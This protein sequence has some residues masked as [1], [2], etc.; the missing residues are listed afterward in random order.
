MTNT[1]TTPTPAKT[2]MTYFKDPRTRILLGDNLY[3]GRI[4]AKTITVPVNKEN[5]KKYGIVSPKDYDKILDTVTLQIASSAQSMSKTDLILLNII[6]NYDWDRPIYFLQRGG[7][8]NIGIKEYLQYE[9]F[10]YKLVPIKSSTAISTNENIENWQLDADKTYDFLMNESRLSSLAADYNVDY[11]NLLTFTSLVPI[12]EIMVN[13]SKALILQGDTTK[14]IN[15]LD[16]MQEV[17]PTNNYPLNVSYISSTN[18]LAVIEAI[19]T[20]LQCGQKE[21]AF[22]IANEFVDETLKHLELQSNK[23]ARIDVL[24]SNLL[25]L[26]YL[27]ENY[28]DLGYVAEAAEIKEIFDSY[29][30]AYNNQ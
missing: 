1:F 4:L 11:Q 14:A 15:L 2:I 25:Y 24:R 5:V 26:L 3:H 17:M 21:K 29:Y 8:V 22:A 27:S 28:Q 16:K 20:Y 23:W 9:G 30:A 13:V 18:D 19:R 12:R 7:D 6:S 10:A